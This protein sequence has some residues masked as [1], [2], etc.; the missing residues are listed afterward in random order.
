MTPN[1]E[2]SKIPS[3]ALLR[4]PKRMY[5]CL[6]QSY[7]TVPST[8]SAPA[9]LVSFHSL[10][11]LAFPLNLGLFHLTSFFLEY[12]SSRFVMSGFL[13]IQISAQIALPSRD[14]P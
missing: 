10:N 9:M 4:S 3:T 7:F 14:F 5:F 13:N 1:T 11:I 8:S 2:K 12:L 6:F